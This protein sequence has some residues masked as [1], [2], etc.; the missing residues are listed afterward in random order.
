MKKQFKNIAGCINN[1]KENITKFI[2]GFIF[3]FVL[4]ILL[5]MITKKI[6]RYRVLYIKYS[7]LSFL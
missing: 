7:F 1:N 4:I 3:N 5:E 2:K 6:T